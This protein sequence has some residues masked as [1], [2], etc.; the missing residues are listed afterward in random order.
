MFQIKVVEKFKTHILCSITFPP[1]SCRLWD[2]V[3]KYGT[4]RQATHD[5]II[6]RMR[7]ACWITK[8]TDT[9]T[10]Y[11]ILPALP[12]Q[13]WLRERASVLRYTYIACLMLHM[14]LRQTTWTS[15]SLCSPWDKNRIS[16]Y[17]SDQRQ[18]LDGYGSCRI[19]RTAKN[20][21]QTAQNISQTAQKISQTAQNISQTAQNISQTAQNI[22]QPA[23]NISQTAQNISQTAQNIS[24]PRAVEVDLYTSVWY[25]SL[26]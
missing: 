22:S 2:N 10:E 26:Y 25:K 17:N 21:S 15:W 14:I 24:Q 16:A 3:E 4:A 1:K 18:A 19:L 13:Q 11:V 12:L 5:N 8:A 6:R 7:F 9:H 20:I 23:Q